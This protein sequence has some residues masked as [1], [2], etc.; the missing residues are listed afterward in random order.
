MKI[1]IL[2]VSYNVKDFICQCIRSI[3]KSNLSK[4]DY[5]IIVV[6]NDSHDDTISV[7]KKEFQELTIIENTNNEG[8]SKAVNQGFNISKGDNI[9]IINPDVI[10]KDDTLQK[11]LDTNSF[12][13][14]SRRHK[15]I[16]KM[17]SKSSVIVSAWQANKLIGFGRATSD[18][19]FR[20]VLWDVVVDKSYQKHGLGTKIVTQIIKNPLLKNVEKI[21][22]N[23]NIYFPYIGLITAFGKTQDGF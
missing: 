7:I 23:G 17:L 13:A 22:S 4:S 14:T 5:E 10:I 9:C 3:Y 21:L 8:F 6:D 12:W 2:I 18:E 20:A 19:V 1:S 15:D 11:L 16:R